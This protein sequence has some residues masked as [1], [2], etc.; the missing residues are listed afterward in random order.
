MK[1]AENQLRNVLY[2]LSITSD[3]RLVVVNNFDCPGLSIGDY[4]NNVYCLGADN[5][6]IWQVQAPDS[7][8]GRDQF[9]SAKNSGAGIIL[10]RGSG[11]TY[12]V[13]T[14]TGVAREIGLER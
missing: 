3:V 10:V 11:T 4:S 9:T 8:H 7:R 14:L 2:E 1:L 13:D 12:E 5:S 6:T